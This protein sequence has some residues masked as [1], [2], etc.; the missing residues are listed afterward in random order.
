MLSNRLRIIKARRSNPFVSQSWDFNHTASAA[1]RPFQT[2]IHLLSAAAICSRAFLCQPR[3]HFQRTHDFS[4]LR[5]RTKLV[6]FKSDWSLTC[7]T[8]VLCSQREISFKKANFLGLL[9][10]AAR[11]IGDRLTQYTWRDFHFKSI[12]WYFNVIIC[13]GERSKNVWTAQS[14]KRFIRPEIYW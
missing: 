3:T 6:P 11:S 9:G 13:R 4:T 2:S 12:H 8:C 14:V 1:S 7:E 5:G 10:S